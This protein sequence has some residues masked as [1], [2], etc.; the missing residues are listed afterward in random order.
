MKKY[1]RE[2]EGETFP[3]LEDEILR[4]WQDQAIL[5]KA[6]ERM[7][8]GSPLVFCDGPP[9]ANAKPHIGHAL[10]RVVKDAFLRYH[11]MNGRR[12]IP[13][14]AG[15][16]CHGLPVELEVERSLGIEN[17]DGIEAL[18]AAKFNALCRESVLK[19]KSDWEEMSRR[20]GYWID[21]E[22]AYMTM[23]REYI[24]SV[25]WSLKQLHGKGMLVKDHRVV[26][27]CPR[28]GTTLSTHEVALGFKETEDRYVVVKFPIEGLGASILVKTVTPWAL[29][30]N[31]LIAV[32]KDKEYR[33][34]ESQGENMIVSELQ[35]SVWALPGKFVRFVKGSELLGLRYTPPFPHHDFGEKGFK[36]VHSSEAGMDNGTGAIGISPAHGS[37]D[38]E[39]G[40]E[41]GV[42][43][44]DPLDDS[45]RFLESV[46]DLAGRQ[47]RGADSE[48]MRILESKG[49]LYRWGLV[50]HSYPFCW[51]CDTGLIY[52]ALDSWFVRTSEVKSRIIE[53]NDQIRWVPPAFKHDRF[54]NFLSDAKDWAIS[55]TRYW[56]TPLPV[57]RCAEGH[58]VCAGGIAELDKLSSNGIDANLDPHRPQIDEVSV[59]CPE[60]GKEMQREPFVIDCWYDSGCA[61]FAQIHYPFDNMQ[62]FDSHRSVDFISEGVDQTRGWFYTQLALG[63]ILFDQPAFLSVLVLGNVHDESGN[64]MERRSDKVVYPSELFS[65]VGADATRLFF[66][67]SP[68]WQPVEFSRERAREE[69][70]RTLTTLLNVYAFFASNANAYGFKE[71]KEYRM[72]HDLDKWIISRLHSTTRDARLGFDSLE[73][74]TAVR[75]LESFIDD[76]SKWYVR[77]SRRRFWEENDPQDRYSAHCALHECLSTF[78]RL[79]APVA[80]FFA[81]WLYRSLNGPKE[82]V[83]LEDY[84]VADE[85]MISLVLEEQMNLVKSAVEAGRLARQKVD[86]KLRQPL[87][88]VVIAVEPD[89]VWALRRYEKMLSEELNVKHVEILES[90]E[91]MIQYAVSA[92][93]RTLGPKLK[94]N[95]GE[96]SKLLSKVDENQLVK[97]LREKGRIRLGG[98]DLTEEDVIVS[99][100]EKKGYSH[101]SAGNLHAYVALEVTQ[102]LKLEGLAREVIRRVQQMRKDQ[103]LDFDTPVKVEYSGPPD[104]E[105]AIT[106][107]K[108]H[109]AHETHAKEIVRK[110]DLE[111]GRKWTVNKMALIL[112]VSPTGS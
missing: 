27:Y 69:M 8:G 51:R 82:S 1:Y 52:K 6:R 39:I 79:L 44:Y 71:Q 43:A 112:K 77:R 29:V 37:L 96:V 38:F 46:P 14:I 84:P 32:D 58:E 55:R 86:M 49:L 34:F 54:G 95:A 105:L 53:L 109:I 60:C 33:V 4:S 56:G 78:S 111:D 18:G 36:I 62:V 57:W 28:C 89:S 83:H 99:E 10:T 67:R 98:F 25:W 19:Y 40:T 63:A 45:G 93:L 21:Y 97:H 9:T 22:D 42:E 11:A 106:S 103:K 66:L 108:V 5:Q 16:D 80:P 48:I 107:H 13:Y 31:A 3:E 88:E 23:S 20:M 74:H 91:K 26:P 47:A 81:D 90:R 102:N 72:T 76:L 2:P 92:N 41:A 104:L 100:K 35:S 68:V 15:W 65:T 85:R 30:G 12:I 87:P 94:D 73:P 50:K 101:A 75:A 61:P 64:R 59:R 70:I 7:K 24:E 17:K 110:D